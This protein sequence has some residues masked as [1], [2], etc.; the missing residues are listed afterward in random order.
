MKRQLPTLSDVARH[1]GVSYATADRVINDRG[2]VAEKSVRRVREAIA[3]LGYVR[4]VAAAN[5][6]QKRT[7]RFVFVIPEGPNSF[8][9]YLRQ[10]LSEVHDALL[11][12]RVDVVVKNVRAFDA[13]ALAQ[14][15]VEL[16]GETLDGVA[17]VGMDDPKLRDAIDRLK[18]QGV[19]VLT[20]VADVPEAGRDLY[21]GIDNVVAGRTAGRLLIL[22]HGGRGG[23]VLPVVGS[24]AAL[25][26]A[27]RLQG[28]SETLA[29]TG[30]GVSMAPVIEGRDLHDHVE[31]LVRQAL[32]DDPEIT[33]I[34]SAGAGNAGLVRVL[35]DLPPDVSRPVVVL[36]ELVPHSRRALQ[37]GLIDL[38]ID[39]RPDD[40]IKLALECL[41]RMADRMDQT[42]PVPIVPAIYVR[43]NLPDTIADD[44]N[45]A[46]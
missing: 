27:E 32:L 22:A 5:L 26:H 24:R 45:G 43:E 44:Q 25:D 7:Y 11:I 30:G 46:P 23:R 41:R 1:A 13:G 3:E 12:E 19:A 4:N 8:F 33:A 42:Q 28:M 17:L 2:G 31:R 20:L 6:S 9:Q 35:E 16:S 39:Q 10:V 14:C 37:D 34:Y 21:V 40:E 18:E 38:V 15:L 36:H 29:E